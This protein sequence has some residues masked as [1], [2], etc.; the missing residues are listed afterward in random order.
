MEGLAKMHFKMFFIK[1]IGWAND[2]LPQLHCHQPGSASGR[3]RGFQIQWHQHYS[4]QACQSR[5]R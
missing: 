5:P 4:F 1:F 3:A 2:S